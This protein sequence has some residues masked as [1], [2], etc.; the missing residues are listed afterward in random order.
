MEEV[1]VVAACRTPIG[2]MGGA[3]KSMTVADLS[4][5]VFKEILKRG[6]ITADMVDEIVMGETRPSA[7]I[8]NVARHAAILAGFPYEVTGFTVQQ[9]C[10]SGITAIQN[11]TNKIMVG[12]ADIMIAGGVESMSNAPFFTNG[13]RYGAGTG[14]LTIYDS[15]TESQIGAQPSSIFGRMTMGPTAETVAKQYGI[16]REEQDALAHQ[17]QVRYQA[18]YEAGKFDE[19]APVTIP[20]KKGDPIVVDKDEHPRLTSP[21]KLATL[22]PVFQKDGTITVGNACGRNDGAAVVLLMS[23]KKVKEL[24]VKPMAK[25]IGYSTAGVDPSVMGIGPVP[26]VRKLL[27]KLD[28]TIDQFDLIELNEAF[29]AQVCACVKELGIDQEKLN[30]NGGA[31]AL[32][33]P[34]GCT[35]G[36]LVGTLCYELQRRPDAK[37]ALATLCV[38]GGFGATV[39]LE[40]V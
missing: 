29:A 31:I 7:A 32:G 3:L 20:Q 12:M 11:A 25:I 10:A 28:M 15:I 1:Y 4:A 36:R 40:K 13:I 14:D 8:H 18:A 5:H 33:H 24:G 38:G 9:A 6:N 19:I 34:A 26:A 21:E 2:K 16:T 39:A 30:V 35:G 17:S 23:G 22:K 37:Y 27:K